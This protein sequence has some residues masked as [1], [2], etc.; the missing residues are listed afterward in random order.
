MEEALVD[1][2]QHQGRRT[3]YQFV[4]KHYSFTLMPEAHTQQMNNYQQVVSDER[5][6]RK[7]DLP[8]QQQT[9]NWCGICVFDKEVWIGHEHK[10]FSEIVNSSEKGVRQRSFRSPRFPLGMVACFGLFRLHAVCWC[11]RTQRFID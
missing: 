11:K 7:C 3:V 2:K 10:Q 5:S 1:R 6:G 9:M 8:N 4:I